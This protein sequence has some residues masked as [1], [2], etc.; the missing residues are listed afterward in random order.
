MRYFFTGLRLPE[1]TLGSWL[2]TALDEQI[3][4]LRVQSGFFALDG[5]APLLSTFERLTAQQLPIR[6]V[7]GSNDGC[8]LH[9]DVRE[10]IHRLGIPKSAAHVGV[11]RFRGSYFH[12]KV[13]HAQRADGTQ[14]AFVGSANLT[15]SGLE[16]HV[17]AGIALD[18]RED[19]PDVLDKIAASIDHWFSSPSPSG[20]NIVDGD[21]SLAALVE[22]GVL[23]LK[24]PPRPS[25]SGKPV[26][27]GGAPWQSRLLSLPKVPRLL[28]TAPSTDLGPDPAQDTAQD[29]EPQDQTSSPTTGAPASGGPLLPS[30]TRT[31][32]PGYLLFEPNAGSPTYG[33]DAL[34]GNSF[35]P[36]VSGL[37][38][39]LNRDSSRNFEG[40]SGTANIS[41]PV[42]CVFTLRFGVWGVHMRPTARFTLEMRYLSDGIVIAGNASTT[43]VMGYGYTEAESGHGDIR[44]VVTSQARAL[45]ETISTASLPLPSDGDLALLEWPTKA[46]P[47][48]RLSFLDPTSSV[49]KDANAL[50]E[51]AAAASALVGNSAWLPSDLLQEIS[52]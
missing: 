11:V 16:L 47:E 48:F 30:T 15:N 45:A 33:A 4:S 36:G 18:S 12:P 1:E 21:A 2:Q 34:T 37:I 20:L 26:S 7:I 17:E 23:A 10:L 39:K 41:L 22:A 44:L 19:P 3:V 9:D 38:V 49:G 13:Y 14:V 32:F 8:T 46:N 50:F 40:R 31:G 35:F 42:G 29:T 51:Q 25:P 5:L 43:S 28:T 52:T 24:P 6:F 27:G